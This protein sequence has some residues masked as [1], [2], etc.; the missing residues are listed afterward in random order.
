MPYTKRQIVTVLS[1]IY[2]LALTAVASYALHSIRYYS[3][4]IPTVLSA[5]TVGLP[6]I[7]GLSIES[8]TEFRR[9]PPTLALTSKSP[10]ERQNYV[11]ITV[12]ILLILETVLATLSGTYLAPAGSLTCPL[13]DQWQKLFHTK[14]AR[15]IKRV[16]DALNC[17]GL[18]SLMD[19]AWPFPT[20]HVSPDTCSKRYDRSNTCFAGWRAEEQKAAGMILL[21]VV[22]VFIWKIL[23]VTDPLDR[24]SWIHR[25]LRI[26][27]RQND[28]EQ[29]E[30]RRRALEYPEA[31]EHYIDDPPAQ[32]GDLVNAVPRLSNPENRNP[33]MSPTLSSRVQPSGLLN[34]DE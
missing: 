29:G 3:L 16:Q 5:L 7:A 13:N 2:L 10:G 8:I 19:K 21:V 33:T 9:R 4:P 32:A 22:L 31:Q 12:I 24:P 14:N 6:A 1:I 27:T 30:D 28:A 18:H 26:P 17:C 11:T 20:K 25:A 23:I 34:R 15:A